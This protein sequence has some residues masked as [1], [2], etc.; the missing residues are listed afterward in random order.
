M[1]SLPASSSRRSSRRLPRRSR[2]FTVLEIMIALAI[3]GLLVGLAVSNLGGT[4]NNAQKD[5]T[6]LFVKTTLNLPL[7]NYRMRMGNYP[8]TAEGLQALIT[9]PAGKAD[10]W[11]TEPYLIGNSVP[12][13][14][15]KE[16]YQY[17]FPGTHN[18]TF[19]DIWSKGPDGQSGTADDI[20][21]WDKAPAEAK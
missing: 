8:T 15:W 18:K 13:D 6:E 20:G 3:I 11:G 4:F 7:Q 5:T 17:A 14:A 9:P 19:P 1:P 12:L 2:G 16:P 10:R 21:N